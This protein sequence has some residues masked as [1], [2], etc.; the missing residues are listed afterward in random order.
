VITLIVIVCLIAVMAIV[1][2]Y[3]GRRY[4]VC[5]TCGNNLSSKRARFFEDEAHC[6]EHGS[7]MRPRLEVP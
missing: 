7:F 1:F 6:S 5:P 2:W 3:D 4:P